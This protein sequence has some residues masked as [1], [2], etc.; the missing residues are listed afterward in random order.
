MKDMRGSENSSLLNS[1]VCAQTICT[2]LHGHTL[3]FT[4]FLRVY[5]LLF[6]YLHVFVSKRCVLS[7][8]FPLHRL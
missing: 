2:Y 5:K 4:R 8:H 1:V 7:L 6:M 3:S